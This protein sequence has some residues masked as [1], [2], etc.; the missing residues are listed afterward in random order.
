MKSFYKVVSSSRFEET[1]VLSSAMSGYL[2]EVAVEYK[3]GQW[4]EPKIEGSK[5]FCFASIKQARS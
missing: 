4:T 5:L 1:E 2:G 3:V